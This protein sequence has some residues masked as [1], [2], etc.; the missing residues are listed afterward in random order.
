MIQRQPYSEELILLEVAAE[1]IKAQ[2]KRHNPQLYHEL[3]RTGTLEAAARLR[4][5]SAANRDREA[6]GPIVR[7]FAGT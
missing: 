4:A 3:A 6:V 7:S 1:K 5:Q 2:W